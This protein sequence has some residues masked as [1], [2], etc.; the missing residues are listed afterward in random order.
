MH[1]ALCI[2]AYRRQVDIGHVYQALNLAAVL[3]KA[4][5]HSLDAI[6][7]ESCSIEWSRNRL[8]WQAMERGA[9]WTFMC[10][11]DTF[12]A[13]TADLIRMI[14]TGEEQGAAVIASP[15]R[16]RGRHGYN[17]FSKNEDTVEQVNPNTWANRVVPV[18]RIGTAYFAIS[19]KWVKDNWPNQPW[20]LTQQL[21]GAE[22]KKIGEDVT[23]CDRVRERGGVILADGRFEPVH[24]GA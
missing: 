7:T 19:T 24:V 17:V 22:P 12:H 21:E 1:I 9:D 8:L 18:D 13:K 20:F 2:P 15:V 23:F 11:A 14:E 4:Q 3:V 16:M 10:D 6:N 5:T